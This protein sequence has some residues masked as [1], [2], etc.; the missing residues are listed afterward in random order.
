MWHRNTNR[1]N[2]V[3][4]IELVSHLESFRHRCPINVSVSL[5]V[6]AIP[7]KPRCRRAL[8][9]DASPVPNLHFGILALR[10]HFE[11]ERNYLH[12]QANPA[13]DGELT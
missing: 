10:A 5:R 7:A 12:I 11:P 13:P 8:W 9:L 4:F 3:I 1:I 2:R 6:P